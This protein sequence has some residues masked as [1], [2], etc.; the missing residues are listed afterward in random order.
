[1]GQKLPFLTA[2]LET[3]STPLP[4]LASEETTISILVVG[5]PT[6]MAASHRP[7]EHG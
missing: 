5:A 6:T 1:M 2:E 3:L 7:I 4:V